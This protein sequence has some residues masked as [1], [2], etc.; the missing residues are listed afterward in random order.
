MFREEVITIMQ[1]ELSRHL[2]LDIKQLSDSHIHIQVKFR[3]KAV[4]DQYTIETKL[5]YICHGG[6]SFMDRVK[7]II[8][9]LI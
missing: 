3:G 8:K 4:G 6:H 2:T 9:K 5:G 1:E 7:L